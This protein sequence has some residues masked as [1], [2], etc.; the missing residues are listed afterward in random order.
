MILYTELQEKILDTIQQNI[1]GYRSLR[2][3]A[4]QSLNTDGNDDEKTL[5][6]IE[7]YTSDITKLTDFQTKVKSLFTKASGQSYSSRTLITELM[8][9]CAESYDEKTTTLTN[10][11]SDI[12]FQAVSSFIKKDDN[13][14]A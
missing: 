1:S 3:S 13:F 11:Y 2:E 10:F 14:A 6:E 12:I 9:L 7:E 4:V 8:K 5:S